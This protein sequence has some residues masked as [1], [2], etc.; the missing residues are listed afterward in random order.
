MKSFAMGKKRKKR[1][2]SF[3]PNHGDVKQAM[4]EYLKQGGKITKMKADEKSYRKY[5]GL[6]NPPRDIDEFLKGN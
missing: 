3:D 4:D 5:A 6:N 2:V 1:S